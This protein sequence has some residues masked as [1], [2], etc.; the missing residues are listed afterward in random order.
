MLLKIQ[1]RWQRAGHEVLFSVKIQCSLKQPLWSAEG[2]VD[3]N[4][5]KCLIFV[6]RLVQNCGAWI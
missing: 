4:R 6:Y 3:K 1:C 5:G 2:K